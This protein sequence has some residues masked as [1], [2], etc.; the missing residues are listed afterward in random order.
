MELQF[1]SPEV[2]QTTTVTHEIIVVEGSAP[3]TGLDIVHTPGNVATAHL[4]WAPDCAE[5][6]IYDVVFTARDDSDPPG[7]TEAT[8]RIVV[9]CATLDCNENGVPDECDGGCE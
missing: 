3:P 1:L 8:L 4:S 9:T 6:G 5:V 7:V 2:G